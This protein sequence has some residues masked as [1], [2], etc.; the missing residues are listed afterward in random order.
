MSISSLKRDRLFFLSTDNI[1][2]AF[3]KLIWK[4]EPA[5]T[6]TQYQCFG[7]DLISKIVCSSN[8]QVTHPSGDLR[9]SSEQTDRN[10]M[11]Y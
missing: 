3:K 10:E 8:I 4:H 2:L 6:N 9:K 7:D 5:I 11:D 1:L